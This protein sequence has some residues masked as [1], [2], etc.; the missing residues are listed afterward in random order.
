MGVILRSVLIGLITYFI[1][2]VLRN[3][4][5]RA[6]VAYNNP[7]QNQSYDQRNNQSSYNS[8]D[9]HQTQSLSPYEILEIEPG[10]TPSEIKQAYRTQLARYHPDKV[11][12]LGKDLQ[13]VAAEKTQQISWAFE[14]LSKN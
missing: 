12:H 1:F 7:S 9:T 11:S 6:L 10:A 4:V 8:H 14:K 3:L 2:R 13:K 5:Y